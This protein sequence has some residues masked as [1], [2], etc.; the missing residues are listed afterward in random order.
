MARLEGGYEQLGKRLD[1]LRVEVVALRTEVAGIRG[2]SR[3]EAATLRTEV[4]AEIGELRQDIRRVNGRLDWLVA[5]VFLAI[6]TPVLVRLFF[7]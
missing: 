2:E 1:D 5:G 7:P 6:L 4:R 3:A